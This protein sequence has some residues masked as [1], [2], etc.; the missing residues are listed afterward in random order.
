MI[1]NEKTVCILELIMTME[2][3]REIRK[4]LI[5][6]EDKGIDITSPGLAVLDEI[7]QHLLTFMS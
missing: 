5:R 3:A 2:D 6:L 7:R 4:A 1:A